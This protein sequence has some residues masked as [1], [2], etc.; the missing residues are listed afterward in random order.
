MKLTCFK[1]TLFALFVSLFLGTGISAQSVISYDMF[2]NNR[3]YNLT[4]EVAD[5]VT[6]E[7]VAFASVYLKHVKDTIITNFALTGP[8]GKI[9]MNDVTKGEYDFYVEFMGYKPYHKTIYVR[10]TIDLK[11]ILLKPDVQA[12]KEAK[13]TANV[14]LMEIKNDTIIYNA[15]AFRTLSNGK[16][17]DL[18]KQMPGVEVGDNGSVK[19]NGKEVSQITVGGR[20][21]FMGDNSVTLNNL[22]ATVVD[23]V[24]VMQKESEAAEFSGIKDGSKKTVMDVELKEEY[25]RGVFGTL[26]AGGGTSVKGNDKTG[27]KDYKDVLFRTSGM[28]SAYGD[29]NQLTV[30]G[31]GFNVKGM[32]SISM[33]GGS[34]D[35]DEKR[36]DPS[37]VHTQWQAGANW[38]TDEI[39]GLSSNISAVF[40][41]NHGDTRKKSDRTTYLD[42]GDD[43][44]DENH[45]VSS[46]NVRSFSTKMEFKKKKTKKFTFKFNPELKISD[47]HQTMTGGSESKVLGDVKNSGKT[48]SVENQ[49][50]LYTYGKVTAGVKNL[51]KK[52]RSIT[53]TGTYS[54]GNFNGDSRENS[55]TWYAKDNASIDRNLFYDNGGYNYTYGGSFQYVEPIGKNWA[56]QG[57]VSSYYKVRTSNSD[58]FNQD[59]SVNDY[60]TSKSENHYISNYGRILGQY[61]KGETNLQFGGIVRWVNNENYSR[62]Y[63]IDT[64][65]G[66]DDWTLAFSPFL[67]FTTSVKGNF[68]YA[69]YDFD[70]ERPS[71]ASIIPSFNILDPTRI[72]AGNIYLHPSMKHRYWFYGDGRF[73]KIRMFWA[74]NFSGYITQ[75]ARVSAIW[76]DENSIRYSIPVNAR[77]PSTFHSLDLTLNKKLTKNGKLSAVLWG[78]VSYSREVNYQSKGVLSGI[79][80]ENMDYKSFM[81]SFWGNSS[82][83]RFYSGESGFIESLTDELAYNV[84]FGLRYNAEVFSVRAGVFMEGGKAKYSI[85]PKAN[86]NIR[87]MSYNCSVTYS[88]PFGFE[89]E[90]F[91]SYV[92]RHG[93]GGEYDKPFCNWTTTLNKNVKAFTFGLEFADILDQERPVSHIVRENYVQDSFTNVLGRN[94]VFSVSWNFGKM[95]AARSNSA[96]RAMANLMMQ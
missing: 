76:F 35:A 87:Q 1:T 59:H 90:S 77:K 62:S 50:T 16:L 95:N 88:A 78:G 27:Y 31:G 71:A 19:V 39:K 86:M 42:S 33:V 45:S 96:Q 93:Y 6:K 9:H 37:G 2:S 55:S 7:P 28:M 5:S 26:M 20:T 68:A 23:K 17:V 60:Y 63:G 44:M 3:A 73:K 75:D 11:K 61:D 21:F 13:V 92:V 84:S 29:K 12:I 80:M 36:I 72:T 54:Y 56:V 48:Y 41:S 14:D 65:T 46:G 74:L 58:A 22:P 66:K 53:V 40:N 34:G 94:I 43:I 38:N 32:N 83:D 67:K 15:A 85:D 89:L 57:F 91:V 47:Y 30:L 69:G 10:K 4:A 64:R 82:G 79:D 49:K 8:D 81:S 70:S 24:K 18:L 25:K 52:R 51:G